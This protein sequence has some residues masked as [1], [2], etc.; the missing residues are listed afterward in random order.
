MAGGR[1]QRGREPWS[2][3]GG[4]KKK[5]G[6]EG[7]GERAWGKGESKRE[8]GAGAAGKEAMGLAVAELERRG[9]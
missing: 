2:C 5:G 9:G 7:N 8:E 6:H 4:E 1:R 3:S